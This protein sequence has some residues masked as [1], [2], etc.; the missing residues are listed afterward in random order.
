M[1][2]SVGIL[3]MPVVV[4]AQPDDPYSSARNCSPD[5]PECN[6][7]ILPPPAPDFPDS[8]VCSVSGATIQGLL[9]CVQQTLI[10]PLI[11]IVL[12]LALLV[13]FWGLAK[14]LYKADNDAERKKGKNLMFFG[15][16][17]LFVMVSVW[18]IVGIIS[19]TF[20]GEG[21]PVAPPI[22]QLPAGLL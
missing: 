10:R 21:G 17:G 13:F 3:V 19:G 5:N 12:S 9:V 6:D 16:I 11:N 14:Y 20:F 8:V 15:V 22:P 4:S 1:C 7:G 2:F 18:G